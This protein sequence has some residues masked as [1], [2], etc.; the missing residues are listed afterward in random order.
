MAAPPRPAPYSCRC[1]M[2]F[3]TG[4]RVQESWGL[5]LGDP[6]LAPLFRGF[7]QILNFPL[8]F[9]LSLCL[10]GIMNK[11]RA[12][13]TIRSIEVDGYG[14]RADIAL[15]RDRAEGV[16]IDNYRQAQHRHLSLP[17]PSPSVNAIPITKIVENLIV[18]EKTSC[19]VWAENVK[20]DVEDIYE[21]VE[22][23]CILLGY[24]TDDFSPYLLDKGYQ[25]EIYL[26]AH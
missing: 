12:K 22:V 6:L 11:R 19:I 23:A 14:D 10:N 8:A 25:L 2:L 5:L 13:M 26:Y 7:M 20:W 24:S 21:A 17:A 15:A 16:K 3:D 1:S 18:Q 4:V 9:H